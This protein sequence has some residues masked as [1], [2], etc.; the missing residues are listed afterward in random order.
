MD[1]GV[2]NDTTYS[3]DNGS[4][5]FDDTTYPTNDECC[6][7]SLNAPLSP[8]NDKVKELYDLVL[9]ELKNGKVSLNDIK[10]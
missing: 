6:V 8:M 7:Q 9:K 1:R 5:C 10:E 4:C 3:C 2:D